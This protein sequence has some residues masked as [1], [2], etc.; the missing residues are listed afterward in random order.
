M[1]LRCDTAGLNDERFSNLLLV[2][3]WKDCFSA[4]IITS[5]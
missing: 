1:I 5:S 3:D 4:M 2:S